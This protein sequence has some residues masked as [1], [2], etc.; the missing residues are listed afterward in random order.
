MSTSENFFQKLTLNNMEYT[1]EQPL[2]DIV[3]ELMDIKFALDQSSIVAITNQRGKITYAN[4]KFCD[5]SKYTKEE[6]IG[7]DHRILNSGYH[8][9]SFFKNMWKTIGSGKIWTGEIRNKAKDGT[10]YWVHTTIV[11][12]LNN[13][14]KPYQ[15]IAIRHDLT[16]LKRVEQ[17]IL[18]NEYHDEVTGL[19]NRQCFNEELH[20]LLSMKSQSKQLAIIFLDI[21]R[22]KYITD[23]LGHSDGDRILKSVSKRLS[24]YFK[25]IG[26]IYRFGGD[27]FIII[28][29][30]HSI[31]KVKDI[32]QELNRVFEKPFSLHNTPYYLSASIG[33]SLSPQD[34]KDVETLVKNA[35]IA[36]YQAKVKGNQSIQFFTNETHEELSKSMKIETALRQAIENEEFVL[37]YQPLIDLKTQEMI[38]VEALIRWNSTDGVISPADFIPVAEE[39][40]MIIPISEWVLETACKHIKHW[41]DAGL[42]SIKVAVNLSPFLFTVEDIAETIKRIIQKSNIHPK[43]LEL[44]ITESIMQNPENAI[45]ILA[46]LK[47]FGI[48][49]SIDDFGTGYSS[50]AQ[51]RRLPIDTLKIDKSFTD[52]IT[53]DG[54]VMVKTILTM[55]SHLN[56]KVISEGI[57]TDEQLEFLTNHS[58]HIGQGYF[59]SKP[60]PHEEISHLLRK[61]SAFI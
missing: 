26:S 45:N 9:K 51:L 36:L 41:Q 16:P 42:P 34:G 59:F 35:D 6:L 49:I 52:D 29:K 38:G 27:E 44:E 57:E 50:L 40:G 23:T 31:D 20:V 30:N 10:Y 43:Y 19:P 18:Y 32:T 5:I 22:F 56:L 15:Y 54:G 2:P 48:S 1:N 24:R 58:C 53:K 37:Y 7:K 33:V 4:Q 61:G 3:K 39:T 25:G 28:L 60:I 8:P 11:P 21:D 46:E 13:H 12:F 14:G 55:A 17:Q 47:S